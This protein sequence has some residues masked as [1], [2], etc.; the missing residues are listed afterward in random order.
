MHRLH[1]LA[2]GFLDQLLA[3][4]EGGRERWLLGRQ[5]QQVVADQHLRIA[6][7][8]CPNTDRRDLDLLGDACREVTRD[9]FENEA[10]SACVGNR[11]KNSKLVPI[12][13]DNFPM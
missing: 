10:V 7:M 1:R 12:H 3:R 6:V 13:F 9:P 8:T 11:V 5:P 2:E 4:Q